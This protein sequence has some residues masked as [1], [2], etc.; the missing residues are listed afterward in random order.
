MK[1]AQLFSVFAAFLLV[2]IGFQNCSAPLPEEA[3]TQNNSSA[4]ATSMFNTEV[5]QV[6]YMSCH[7]LGTNFD[8]S[9][10][11]TFRVGAYGANSGIGLTSNF[12]S[13]MGA[14]P[15]S[16]WKAKIVSEY[17]GVQ[18]VLSIRDLN[19]PQTMRLPV[20]ASS[21]TAGY[22]HSKLLD[23]LSED[24]MA[25]EILKDTTKLVR[26]KRSGIPE[27]ARFEGDLNLNFFID[28]LNDTQLRL[29]QSSVLGIN[30]PVNDKSVIGIRTN[31]MGRVLGE[32]LSVS[33]KNSHPSATTGV[34]WAL[35]S[36]AVQDLET[37]ATQGNML[38]CPSSLVFKIAD[39]SDLTTNAANTDT[40]KIYC[41]RKPDS[42]SSLSVADR[43]LLRRARL[44]LRVEDW[45][46]DWTRKCIVPKKYG[47][48]KNL[49]YGS[50]S[51]MVAIEYD[52][53]KTCVAS[54]TTTAVRACVALASICIK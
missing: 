2:V 47:D 50:A 40:T 39:P 21:P 10:F 9:T 8:R 4:S 5:D 27:G 35:N 13:E 22:D 49:C 33:F 16:D 34:T 19:N 25:D 18:P 12:I 1:K 45:F 7:Q 48:G 15:K 51:S 17:A 28:G 26:Y 3:G 52:L 53:T 46:I 20:G 38:S 30:Y 24:Y 14:R 6:A 31:S 42:P 32:G 11:F 44:S 41:E 37:G 54:P 29:S 23:V 36:A 43:E